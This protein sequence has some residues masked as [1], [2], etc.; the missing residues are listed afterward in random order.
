MTSFK[1][2]TGL[3]FLVAIG[4]QA[5]L[6]AWAAEPRAEGRAA[7]IEKLTACRKITTDAERLACYDG[8]ASEL[9]Q[10]EAKGDV[11][12]IDR[13]QARQVRRQAFGFSLPSISLFER[14]EEKEE[15]D[16][17]EST[18]SSARQDATGK[19]SLKLENG[20]TWTQVDVNG[21]SRTPKTGL[22]VRI[23]KASMG[24]FLLSIEGGRAFRAR[25]T[26]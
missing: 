24:S 14:G 22:A 5:A 17:I 8:A 7:V 6:P 26:D 13:E 18:I 16:S 12:V 3:T 10:A 2:L 21:P 9:E 11:V 23:R 1:V 25:R 15:L 19:W 20:S 4:A